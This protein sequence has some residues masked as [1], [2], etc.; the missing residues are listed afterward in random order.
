M[1]LAL[2][3]AAAAARTL[4]CTSCARPVRNSQSCAAATPVAAITAAPAAPI[5][6]RVGKTG[7]SP[8]KRTRDAASGDKPAPSRIS[9]KAIIEAEVIAGFLLLDQQELKRRQP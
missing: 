7:S 4:T 2:R 3:S 9:F 8:L 1:Y 5:R 6:Y